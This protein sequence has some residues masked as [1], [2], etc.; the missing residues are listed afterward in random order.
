MC[1]LCKADSTNPNEAIVFEDNDTVAV[2]SFGQKRRNIGAILV[3]PKRH[4]RDVYTIPDELLA[5]VH[6]L[7]KRIS[8]AMKQALKC[9]GISI[10]QNND[11]AGDQ[12]VFHYHVHVIP[13]FKDDNFRYSELVQ[14]TLEERVQVRDMIKKHL[15][16]SSTD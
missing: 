5:K 3:I 12:D 15:T 14:S 8:L 4:F 1:V 10:R 6:I 16:S 7:A 2:V 11:E 9:D 13:R